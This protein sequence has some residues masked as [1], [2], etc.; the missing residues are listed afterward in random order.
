MLQ[1]VE[2]STRVQIDEVKTHNIGSLQVF[3]F[4]PTTLMLKKEIS[5]SLALLVR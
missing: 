4:P 1:T 5:E 2:L 3:D